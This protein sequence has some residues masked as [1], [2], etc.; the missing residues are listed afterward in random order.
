MK[1]QI[2]EILLMLTV[3]AVHFDEICLAMDKWL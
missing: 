2:E 1:R 3:A